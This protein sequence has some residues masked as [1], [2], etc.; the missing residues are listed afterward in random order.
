MHSSW[1]YPGEVLFF[2]L[3]SRGTI[4]QH[5]CLWIPCLMSHLFTSFIGFYYYI[6]IV[7]HYINN[8]H[9]SGFAQLMWTMAVF[10]YLNSANRVRQCYNAWIWLHTCTLITYIT[11]EFKH[12][13]SYNITHF[14]VLLKYLLFDVRLL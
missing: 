7:I 9:G 4:L 14:F 11:T 2:S 3:C 13:C 8:F 10:Q 12:T 6:L 1:S 5:Y